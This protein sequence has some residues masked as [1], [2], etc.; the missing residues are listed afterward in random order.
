MISGKRGG[1]VEEHR[2]RFLG[3]V[4]LGSALNNQLSTLN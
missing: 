1:A 2:R 4:F 3:Q